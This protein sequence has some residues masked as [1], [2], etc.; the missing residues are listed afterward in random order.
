[1]RAVAKF[2]REDLGFHVTW[3]SLQGLTLGTIVPSETK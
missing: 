2:R 3:V 1:M